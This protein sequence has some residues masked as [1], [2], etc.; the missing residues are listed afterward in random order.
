MS[1]LRYPE[2][3]DSSYRLRQGPSV[4]SRKINSTDL[5]LSKVDRLAQMAEIHSTPYYAEGETP[6]ESPIINSPKT[7]PVMGKQNLPDC[8][9]SSSIQSLQ[10]SVALPSL[11]PSRTQ[12]SI[13]SSGSYSGPNTQAVNTP[14]D[15]F[16][17]SKASHIRSNSVLSEEIQNT[18][19]I[20]DPPPPSTLPKSS[21][22]Q[23]ELSLTSS[24]LSSLIFSEFSQLSF[25][26]KARAHK[27]KNMTSRAKSPLETIG[28]VI[29]NKSSTS[30]ES[31][32]DIAGL[33]P[34]LSA[35]PIQHESPLINEHDHSEKGRRE[36][37]SF[38]TTEVSKLAISSGNISN[39]DVTS[40]RLQTRR[41][42]INQE[43]ALISSLAA[44][45]AHNKK[46]E[47]D[48]NP[49]IVDGPNV[50]SPVISLTSFDSIAGIGD[51]FCSCIPSPILNAI[52]FTPPIGSV[53]FTPPI[54][55]AIMVSSSDDDNGLSDM[56]SIFSNGTFQSQP[57]EN[58]DAGNEP[59][60]SEEELV[61]ADRS[62]SNQHQ[63]RLFVRVDGLSDLKL[64][65]NPRRNPKFTM[66]LDNG[67]QT[68]TTDPIK[69]A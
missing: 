2:T 10:D 24:N 47:K 55:G 65:I 21:P 42:E 67:R 52:S 1:S 68:V 12:E 57:K 4:I 7:K 44:R 26:A 45:K 58:P 40:E 25:E 43:K 13:L 22:F 51:Q 41:M 15:A 54:G 50:G 31:V 5:I 56:D 29:K 49:V 39:S 32:K 9:K 23:L 14:V 37:H 20:S 30:I 36:L 61:A 17:G 59:A 19:T 34:S 48:G 28:S 46:N 64:P 3:F 63:G 6:T 11:E 53:P 27:S 8:S 60:N 66:T 18:P 69:V 35:T 16:F 33:A 38:D 62:D